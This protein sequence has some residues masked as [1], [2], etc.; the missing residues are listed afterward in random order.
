MDTWVYQKNQACE[1]IYHIRCN[2]SPGAIKG[3]PHDWDVADTLTCHLSWTSASSGPFPSLSTPSSTISSACDIPSTSKWHS[4]LPDLTPHHEWFWTYR[5]A[6][7]LFWSSTEAF[8]C[9]CISSQTATSVKP[10]WTLQPFLPFQSYSVTFYLS[11]YLSIYL[12]IH[13]HTSLCEV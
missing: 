5:P 2:P 3:A 6:L 7:L 10:L 8:S 9:V 11:I 13:T 12:Y 4:K 1:L